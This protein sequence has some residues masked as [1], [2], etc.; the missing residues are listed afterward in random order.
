MFWNVLVVMMG[1]TPSLYNSDIGQEWAWEAPDNSWISS[2]PPGTDLNTGY[3]VGD[4]VPDFRLE[5]QFG[6]TVSMWQF[7]GQ[8]V[9]LDVAT[10]WCGPCRT[11]GST[12]EA[13]WEHYKDDGFIYLTVLQEN[14][15]D[16]PP[17]QADLEAWATLYG[18]TQPVLGDGDKTTEG[19]LKHGGYPAVLVIDRD[20]T[21]HSRIDSTDVAVHAALDDMF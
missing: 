4:I 21:V 7:Y 14:M 3:Y 1:C 13:T 15:D 9:L 2:E 8:V 6:E 18:I 16:G 10:M 17:S 19:A 11:L 5:D 12:S 20:L